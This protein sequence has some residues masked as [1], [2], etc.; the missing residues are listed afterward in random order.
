MPRAPSSA[1]SSE[2]AAGHA[3]LAVRGRALPTS[4]GALLD[5]RPADE[6]TRDPIAGA[7]NI[8]LAELPRRMHE[9]PPRSETVLIA[10]PAALAAAAAEWCR[11]S[12]R[13]AEV[14]SEYERRPRG[15]RPGLGRL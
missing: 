1:A 12:G 7:V 11:R 13:R 2:L 10:G 9:L 5:P 15:R 3:K 8:P 14:T 4:T 6:A